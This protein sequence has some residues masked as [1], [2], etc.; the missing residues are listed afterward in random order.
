MIDPPSRPTIIHLVPHTHWDRE[1]YRPFQSFRMQ[2]VDLVDR[3]LEMLEAQPGFAFTLDG[4]LAT[5]DDYLEIR[6][7]QAERIAGHVRSGRLAIGPWQILMDEFLVSG[8]TLV[9]N[10]EMG[11]QRAEDFGGPMKV[12]YLPDMFG[13]VAQMPQ[14]LRKAGLADAV[15]WRGVPAAVD[16]HAFRWESPDGSWVRAEYLP[17]GY[18]N[19]AHLFAV[20]EGMNGAASRLLDWAAPWFGTDPVLAMY[21]TD[22]TVPV[23]ELAALVSRLNE[24]HDASS[25]RISTLAQ[26][27]AQ[28]PALTPDDPSWRG[29]MRSG[30]RANLLMGVA[31]ARIDIKQAAGRA[32]TA[33]ERYAEPL[34]ALHVTPEAWP[35]AFLRLAWDKVVENSAHDSICGCSVDPVV[36]Q[37]LV[38]FAEAEQIGTTVARRAAAAVAVAVPRGAVTILNPSPSRRS[39]LVE[40]ELSVPDDWREV[41]LELPDGARIGTQELSRKE[42]L[43]YDATLRGGEV[44]DLFRRFHGREIFDHSWNGYRIDGRTLTLEVD[45]DPDPAWLDVDEL[46]AEVTAALRAAP[47]EVWQVRIVARPR[48][49]LAASVPAPALGWTALRPVEGAAKVADAARVTA[50]GRA[51]TNGLL[52]V[53]VEDDGTLRLA[54]ADG[55]AAVGVGR[56]TDGG[57]FGDS[58]NYG[59]PAADTVVERPDSVSVSSDLAGPVR[60]R[61]RVT[62]TFAWP[63]GVAADGSAR[64]N[65]TDA[66]EVI[67]EVELRAGEPFARLSVAFENRSDDHRVRFHAPLPRRAGASH[68]EGQ[69]AV[70]ERGPA[71][72]GGY[73]EEPLGTYP[74]H[75]W[76][77]AGGLAILLDHL[78]EYELA[79]EGREIALT[80]LRSIGLISRNANP[81]RQD[82]AGPEM[83]IP[84]AQIRGGWR[85]SFGLL[86]HAGNWADGGVTDA[87]ER[88]RHPFIAYPGIAAADAAWPPA[89][90]GDDALSLEGGQVVLSSLRRRDDGWL[91]ARIVNLAPEPRTATLRGGLSEAREATLR[92]EPGDALDVADGGLH[93]ELRPAEI[94]TVQVRRRET[95][96]GR[97]AVLDVSVPR[98]ST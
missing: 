15:V 91:E 11:W 92:G 45:N 42:P 85:L 67:T 81:Y 74:A 31:S 22:H 94:R 39:G 66:S 86:P 98:H 33:L 90:A 70:V 20:S 9:R 12:G 2:L 89:G 40:A 73:G 14:I 30:A 72:E 4:Q 60:A 24:V 62:R 25:M 21:G 23:P 29:E 80:V 78:T 38:R 18:G 87:A 68:A 48:R 16:R 88:H 51:M 75:G 82:P 19:A 63:R 34:T 69:F 27:V 28:A 56:I 96:R 43:L 5:I 54:A 93:F 84:N 61:L 65:E 95:G 6:P 71:G 7:E 52:T 49:R 83:A 44:D 79:D 26:Y 58:Y 41:A 8:E 53:T 17:G 3:V 36:D 37:V 46:R 64:T 47:D 55:T 59:A 57:D 77:D 35:A 13:H 50:D 76:V 10:L 1:W 97:A 32:E